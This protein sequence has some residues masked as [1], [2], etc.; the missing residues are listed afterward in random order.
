MFL[1]H[2]DVVIGFLND[3][4]E[5]NEEDGSVT[6]EV[7]LIGGTMLQREISMLLSFVDDT[8]TS[9]SVADPGY[10]EKGGATLD[11]CTITMI[12]LLFC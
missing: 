7:G 4:Y 11:T 8:A 10:L 6:I 3:S 12:V 9:K 5:V 1:P 2:A